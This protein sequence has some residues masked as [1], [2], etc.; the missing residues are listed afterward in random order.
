MATTAY[1]T[2]LTVD[3]DIEGKRRT[4]KDVQ[5]PVQTGPEPNRTGRVH[6]KRGIQASEIVPLGALQLRLERLLSLRRQNDAPFIITDHSW[7]RIEGGSCFAD[8]ICTL[9]K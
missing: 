2:Q 4:A 8:A 9:Y 1:V 5:V 3:S 6:L 7:M